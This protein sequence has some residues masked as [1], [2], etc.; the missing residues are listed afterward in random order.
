M[1]V[2]ILYAHRAGATRRYGTGRDGECE[3]GCVGKRN[4]S[5]T[6][7]VRYVLHTHLPHAEEEKERTASRPRDSHA[8]RKMDQAL[9]RR[10]KEGEGYKGESDPRAILNEH[11]KR[12]LCALVLS[13][14]L[15]IPFL[16][17]ESIRAAT[18]S[19]PPRIPREIRQ[20]I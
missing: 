13:S 6:A 1:Y 12:T 15:L 9:P 11:I 14:D 17:L 8:T 10:R 16:S 4:V 3:T 20:I 7:G 18:S 5:L 19:H 2:H